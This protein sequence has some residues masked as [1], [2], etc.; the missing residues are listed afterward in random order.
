MQVTSEGLRVSS[1]LGVCPPRV[2]S[3]GSEVRLAGAPPVPDGEDHDAVVIGD[4]EVD[5]VADATK[6]DPSNL[7][8]LL[9]GAADELGTLLQ[10]V[11][12]LGE[13]V[14]ERARGFG[15]V[16]EPPLPGLL[17]LS[18]RWGRELD[19]RNGSA[20]AAEGAE[21]VAR[22]EQI[23]AGRRRLPSRDEFQLLAGGPD[24]T[25]W[26]A[27]PDRDRSSLDQIRGIIQHD[28]AVL[29]SPET[30]FHE[31]ILT[32]ERDDARPRLASSPMS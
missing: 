32:W 2:R 4:L 17:D 15:A 8:L 22:V 13:V 11:D 5:E 18:R 19:G 27:D 23:A 24:G 31:S 21:E 26:I 6:V 25:A 30:R 12:Q 14:V 3:S 1:G 20:L 16:F 28:R 10:P 9:Q 29:D 7:R